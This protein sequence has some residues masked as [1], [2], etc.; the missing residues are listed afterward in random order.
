MREVF[1]VVIFKSWVVLPLE[2]IN[3]SK[4]NKV[5]VHKAAELCS[6]CWRLRCNVLYSP[7]HTKQSL[8]KEIKEIKEK[9]AKGVKVNY[10]RHVNLCQINENTA[11]IGGMR[12]WIKKARQ[13]R[14]NA[15]DRKQ[16][17][18]RKF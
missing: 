6:E 2:S 15:F 7:E 5:L 1:R 10:E 16:Q 18:I 14:E 4:C 9:V 3:F 13:F 17:A 8:N 11:T 12:S